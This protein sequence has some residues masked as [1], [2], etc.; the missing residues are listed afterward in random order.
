MV[1]FENLMSKQAE[2]AALAQLMNGETDTGKIQQLSASMQRET[3]ILKKMAGTFEQEQQ[4]EHGISPSAGQPPTPEQQQAEAQTRIIA[5]QL[6]AQIA[7]VSPAAADAVAK[8]KADP[9]FM[10]GILLK[11]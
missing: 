2:I 8:L 9:T 10:G 6:L 4:S 5:E 11:K 3:E 1:T 7:S